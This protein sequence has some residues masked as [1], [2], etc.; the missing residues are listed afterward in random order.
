MTVQRI[1]MKGLLVYCRRLS[2][3]IILECWELGYLG[4]IIRMRWRKHL[5]ILL[6]GS[7]V[8]KIECQEGIGVCRE[9]QFMFRRVEGEF[10]SDLF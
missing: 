4:L 10:I 7:L 5:R 1:R 8:R 2:L 6:L 9:C 3:T